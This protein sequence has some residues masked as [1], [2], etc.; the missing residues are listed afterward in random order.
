MKGA[1]ADGSLVPVPAL[2]AALS[3]SPHGRVSGVGRRRGHAAR[4]AMAA[5]PLARSAASVRFES[6]VD[7]TV[8]M[9]M[10]GRSRDGSGLV[11]RV[12]VVGGGE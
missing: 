5:A 4:P 1:L 10:D 11:R 12:L 7:S 3:E 6:T 8:A 9:A 2:A